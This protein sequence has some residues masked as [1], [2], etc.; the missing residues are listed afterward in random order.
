M[1]PNNMKAAKAFA[2]AKGHADTKNQEELLYEY[3]ARN[4][5]QKDWEK[6]PGKSLQNELKLKDLAKDVL[7]KSQTGKSKAILKKSWL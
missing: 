6:I 1:F 5:K 2:M 3:L 4:I 7:S